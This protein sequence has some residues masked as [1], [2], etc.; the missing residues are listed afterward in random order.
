[1]KRWFSVFMLM[2][3]SLLWSGNISAHAESVSTRATEEQWWEQIVRLFPQTS[4]TRRAYVISSVQSSSGA[5]RYSDMKDQQQVSALVHEVLLVEETHPAA[6]AP[7]ASDMMPVLY[8]LREGNLVRE[9]V[10]RKRV[11]NDED[12]SR[13]HYQEWHAPEVGLV[14]ATVTDLQSGTVIVHKELVHFESGLSHRR[15]DVA[16]GRFMLGCVSQKVVTD[17][18]CNMR[19]VHDHVAHDSALFRAVANATRTSGRSLSSFPLT[20]ARCL[21]G[22]TSETDV[23]ASRSGGVPRTAP[24]G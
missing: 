10:P 15:I 12:G 24:E 5:A 2:G 17:A 18:R 16:L 9:T 20:I 23:S 4:G 19:V 7:D 13:Y 8:Y 22:G 11:M 14:K 6:I 3:S 21:C 1:M